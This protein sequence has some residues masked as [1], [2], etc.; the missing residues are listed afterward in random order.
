MN[1]VIDERALR[2]LYLLPFE[3]AVKEGGALGLMTSYNRFNGGYCAE[4]ERLLTGI[5]REE[6]GFEGFVV[7]DWGAV[8]RRSARRARGL[9]LE[10]P[11]PARSF[12]A[13]LADGGGGAA[14]STETAV[15]RRPRGACSACLYRLG[16]L[17]DAADIEERYEDRP[18]IAR[19]RARPPPTSMVLLRNDGRAPAR[20][21]ARCARSR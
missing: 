12:G 6:W 2:E 11:G 8:A 5:L 14:R 16:A 15:D 17:D 3:L 9:D 4:D 7:S 20:R 13:H 18:S 10:M 19:S 21:A 1:S